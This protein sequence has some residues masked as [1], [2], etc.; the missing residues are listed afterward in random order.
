MGGADSTPVHRYAFAPFG[1]GV[2]TCI[3]QQFA[4]MNVKAIMHQLLRRHVW[5][6]PSGYR[7]K[8]TWGTGSTPTDGLP[9]AIRP[10]EA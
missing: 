3:G 6:V 10:L 2:H 4:D 7:P 8:L 9:I 5:W 1:G